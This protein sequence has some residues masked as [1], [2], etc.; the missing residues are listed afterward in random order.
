MWSVGSWFSFEQKAVVLGKV[1]HI[2][3]TIFGYG[4]IMTSRMPL[5]DS[6]EDG[7]QKL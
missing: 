7:N 2:Q 6:P 5:W 4:V 1:M 3:K